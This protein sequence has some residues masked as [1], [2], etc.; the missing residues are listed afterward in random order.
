MR[1]IQIFDCF[2][3]RP[4]DYLIN[5][6]L[7]SELYSANDFSTNELQRPSSSISNYLKIAFYPKLKQ[8][9]EK[10]S[11]NEM[12][13]CL[14]EIRRMGFQLKYL[15]TSSNLYDYVQGE[16]YIP[17]LFLAIHHRA[18]ASIKCLIE[19]GIPL[20]GQLFV[21]KSRIEEYSHWIQYRL[22]PNQDFECIELEDLIKQIE[23]GNDVDMK[24]A[25]QTSE[26]SIPIEDT[27]SIELDNFSMKQKFLNNFFP[28]NGT[29]SQMCTVS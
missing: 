4:N 3:F 20:T 21:S 17:L 16:R 19:F 8:A 15:T 25:F 9:I 2:N 10:D 1:S 27:K 22:E 28:N 29:N 24:N 23:T 5:R 7:C 12:K 13:V 6:D 18:L 14:N 11:I 26:I